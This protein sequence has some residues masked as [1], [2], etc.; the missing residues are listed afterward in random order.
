[1]HTHLEANTSALG[2][3]RSEAPVSEGRLPMDEQ[4]LF[5]QGALVA[6]P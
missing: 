1:M 5:A 6:V 2:A 4:P 3:E